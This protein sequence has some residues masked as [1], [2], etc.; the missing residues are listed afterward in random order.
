MTRAELATIDRFHRRFIEAGVGLRFQSTGRPPQS[1]YPTYRDLLLA[2]DS[3]GERSNYLASEEAYQ[4]VKGLEQR[5]LVIPVVGDLSGSRA[6]SAI[7]SHCGSAASACRR[8]M[9]P[10]SSSTSSAMDDSNAS[11]PT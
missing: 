2:T 4:F 7:G 5:D 3:L 11:S 10:M 1:H 8:S 6:L 9:P